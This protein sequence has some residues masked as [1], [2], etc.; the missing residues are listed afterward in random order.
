MC[1]LL[2]RRDPAAVPRNAPTGRRYLLVDDSEAF[3]AAARALLEREGAMVVGAVTTGAEAIRLA[4]VLRPDVI[5]VDFDLGEECGVDV[6]RAL[7]SE[8]SGPVVLVSA[9]PESEFAEIVAMSPVAGFLSK[10]EP[11]TRAVEALLTGR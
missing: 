2:V 7:A 5:L 3:L 1:A 6:A 9:Y 4:A 10:S 11:S 8:G